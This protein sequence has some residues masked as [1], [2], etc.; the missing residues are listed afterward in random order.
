MS[1]TVRMILM[2]RLRI[3]EEQAASLG[4]LTPPNILMEIEDLRELLSKGLPIADDIDY[5]SQALNSARTANRDQPMIVIVL[6]TAINADS[7]KSL[8]E[9]TKEL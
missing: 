6:V 9:R 8:M 7:K 2:R 3:R 1:P 5:D 4:D